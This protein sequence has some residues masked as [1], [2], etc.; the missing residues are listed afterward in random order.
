MKYARKSD[1]P[2]KPSVVW[3][4]KQEL[5]TV[6]P[7][8][9]SKSSKRST[10]F[11][12][13]PS[14]YEDISYQC[15]RCGENAVFTAAEQKLTFEGRKAYIW[16]RRVVCPDCWRERQRIERGIRECTTRWKAHKTELQRDAEFLRRWFELLQ[17][18]PNYGGRK[19]HAGI[20]M[21]RRLLDLSA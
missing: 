8:Q 2:R 7:N 18:Y 13:P 12:I 14:H 17:T 11:H 19:N 10:I 9:W 4:P 6:N 15:A 3:K 16:Q 5:Q 20:R 21:L 1:Y